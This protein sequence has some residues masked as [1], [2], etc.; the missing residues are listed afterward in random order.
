MRV[1]SGKQACQ[2]RS[3]DNSSPGTDLSAIAGA[4]ILL[5][6]DNDLNQEVAMELLQQAGF[7][8]DVAGD[9]VAV[10]LDMVSRQDRDNGYAIVLMDRQMP[11][12][13]GVTATREIRKLPEWSAL[14]IVAMTANAMAGDR[15]RCIEAG[16]NDHVAKPIDP[17]QLW[18]TLQ[19]WIKPLREMSAPV[20]GSMAPAV[21]TSAV[22]TIDP[23]TG[24][25]VKV[26][27]RH[28]MGRAA[29]Y[30]SLLR[31][32]SDGQRDFPVR[33]A[34]AL[35]VDDWQTV[36]RLVHTLKGLC[37]Q[38]GA[39][40]LRVMAESLEQRIN[41]REPRESIAASLEAI[42]QPLSELIAAISVRL[43]VDEPAQPAM[44]V[45]VVELREICARLAAELAADD[46]AS[47]DTFDGHEA[48]M[49][50]ALGDRYT[51][52]SGA[53]Y[54]FNFLLALDQ[55]RDAVAEHGIK[56]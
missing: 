38:I 44:C 14:S 25:D 43:P 54:D 29:L 49:R 53:I 28:S 32:F 37:A 55:L 18:S 56:L 35:A 48:L 47:G 2:P 20:P 22:A 5:V 7:L 13:D 26:G 9:G 41:N 34:D 23:I 31:K 40:E 45:D 11:V 16:M 33:L 24:L 27:L 50:A 17:D 6:E 30:L 15:D 46:F 42:S 51:A 3:A 21:S 39:G 4:R 36:E 52:I 10:A 8:V 12:M 19:R 1:L